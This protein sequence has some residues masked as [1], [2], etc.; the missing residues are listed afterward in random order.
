VCYALSGLPF[1]Q[2]GATLTVAG[3]LWSQN[4]HSLFYFSERPSPNIQ[5]SQGT[6][7]KGIGLSS[8]AR[9]VKV[10]IYLPQDGKIFVS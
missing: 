9:V 2:V 10:L 1:L 5:I 6:S 4:K 3:A 8:I 7:L